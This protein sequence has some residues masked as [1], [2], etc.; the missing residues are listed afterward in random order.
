MPDFRVN[1]IS[2]LKKVF[3]YIEKQTLNAM[4]DDV[5]RMVYD[6]VQEYLLS[7]VY[8]NDQSMYERTYQVLRALS[9]GKAQKQGNTI[10]VEIYI[11]S[12]K[13]EPILV[14]GG[15]N[16][17]ASMDASPFNEYLPYVLEYGANS[18]YYDTPAFEYMKQS[19]EEIL[20]QQLHIKKLIGYL[21]TKGIQCEYK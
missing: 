16:K 11:D 13:I 5:A 8:A 7:T 12:D 1:N 18:P 15:W 14:D 19:R 6:I 10:S 9:I 21:K 17:H 2:D 20:Q 3:Q 4:Q